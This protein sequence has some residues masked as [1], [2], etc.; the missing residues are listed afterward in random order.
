[1]QELTQRVKEELA[2]QLALSLAKVM[3]SGIWRTSVPK[4]DSYRQATEERL[5]AEYGTTAGHL[6]HR[7][8]RDRLLYVAGRGGIPPADAVYSLCRGK[9]S[10]CTACKVSI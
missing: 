3:L 7:P 9:V 4:P 8:R 5:G 1:M 10:V 2:N 6:G